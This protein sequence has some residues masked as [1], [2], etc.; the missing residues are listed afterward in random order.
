M[1]QENYVKLQ[2]DECGEINYRV[3]KSK[4]IKDKL[5]LNKHCKHCEKHTEHKETK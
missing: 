4:E 5:E 2:C 1:S 3:H